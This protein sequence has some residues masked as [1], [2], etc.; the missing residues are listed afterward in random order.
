METASVREVQHN[1]ARILRRVEA[2]SEVLI[3]RR[4]R[5]IARLVPAEQSA[6]RA[7]DWSTQGAELARIFHG[8]TVSGRPMEQ[9]VAEARGER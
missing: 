6:E 8:R 3:H 1:L 5:P 7:A 2:C 9:V 4:H